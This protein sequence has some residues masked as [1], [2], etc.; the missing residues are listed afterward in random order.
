MGI[1]N[2]ELGDKDIKI[3][4]IYTHVTMKGSGVISQFESTRSVIQL[5][6]AVEL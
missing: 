5:H 1:S 3:T 2:N 4:M 6:S